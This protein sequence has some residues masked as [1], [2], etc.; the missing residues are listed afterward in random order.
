[1]H[2]KRK[3]G[4]WSARIKTPREGSAESGNWDRAVELGFSGDVRQDV[5]RVAAKNQTSWQTKATKHQAL[6]GRGY[7]PPTKHNSQMLLFLVRNE[8]ILTETDTDV[9]LRKTRAGTLTK[10]TVSQEE[11]LPFFWMMVFCSERYSNRGSAFGGALEIPMSRCMCEPMETAQSMQ[12]GT[13]PRWAREHGRDTE[14]GPVVSVGGKPG[15]STSARQKG[16]GQK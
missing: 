7:H 11:F 8:K 16:H 13:R 2:P 1:M 4:R 14:C 6:A 10:T 9:I 15:P 12:L 5:E 3:M